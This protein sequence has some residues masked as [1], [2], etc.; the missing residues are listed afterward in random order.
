MTLERSTRDAPFISQHASPLRHSTALRP[1]TAAVLTMWGAAAR[2]ETMAET[3][4]MLEARLATALTCHAAPA[5]VSVERERCA[6][7]R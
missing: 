1:A 4:C 6:L 3:A 2:A 5:G 7:F